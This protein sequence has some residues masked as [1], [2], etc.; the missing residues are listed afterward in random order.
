MKGRSLM[1]RAVLVAIAASSFTVVAAERLG[2]YPVDP[3]KVSISGI[4]S[5]AFMANQFHV[6]HSSLVM[7]AGMVAGGLYGCSLD[8][9]DGNEAVAFISIATGACMSWPNGLLTAQFYADRITSFAE[10]GWID[11][12]DGISGDRIYFFTGASDSVVNSETVRRG[13]D[14]YRTLGVAQA[15]LE[16]LD[17]SGPGKDAGHSWVTEDFGVPCKDNRD[18]YI[19]DCDYDQAGDVLEH[20]YGE[21]NPR[22]TSL[23][24]TFVE[25]DQSEFAPN[26]R[27]TEH[28]LF[29][30]GY[31]YV[32]SAC[33][34]EST[35]QCPLH[36]V[37][38]GCKQSV[39]QLGDEFYRNVGVNEWADSN[40]IIVLYP[41]ARTVSTEDFPEKS[42][43]DLFEINPEGCWNWFGYAYDE[44][45]LFKDGV[46]VTAI[47]NMIQRIMG[48]D[49]PGT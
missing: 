19:N 46:Q 3:E 12:L 11:P 27:P 20:I 42:S 23:S 17:S 9:V 31:L 24:G 40:G 48:A 6:A 39:Q 2:S 14:V 47:Y 36:V 22:S 16:I 29:D 33:A 38:H 37:L 1:Y 10:R 32:P 25:F 30:A 28:G 18:P 21:L 4:S 45:F 15:D 43:S 26:G 35:G 41:Q 8:R 34:P 49:A 5:G 44:R 13:A 7:G